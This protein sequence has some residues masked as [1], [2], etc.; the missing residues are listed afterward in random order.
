MPHESLRAAHTK[1]WLAKAAKDLRLASL[2]L[3]AV[4]PEPEDALF[5]CQQAVEKVLKAF[6]TWHDQPFRK[7][8]DLGEL[9][10]QCVLI[11][12]RLETAVEEAAGLSEYAW[13]HRYP[14]D[15]P[16]P[17]VEEAQRRVSEARQVVEAV[18]ARIPDEAHP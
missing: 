11:D 13:L 3:S 2:V 18:R 12:P 1:Q 10:K 17:G 7:V 4:P 9:G 6:L 16:P 5:H 14:G 8:H 15:A